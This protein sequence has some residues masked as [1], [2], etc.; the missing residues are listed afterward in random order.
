MNK[1]LRISFSLKNS[2]R[3]NSILYSLKQIPLVK[4]L[5]PNSLYQVQGLKIFANI[6]SV[7][8][9]IASTFLGKFLYFT[10]MIVGAANLYK[11]VPT[12]GSTLHILLFLSIIGAFMNTYM[13]NP[14]RDKYYAMIL[15]R[16][17]A[18]DYTLINYI[19]SILKIIIGF[20]PFVLIYGFIKNI[21]LWLCLLIPFFI[22]GLKLTMTAFFLRDYEKTGKT[23]N[24][25]VLGK[26]MW[27]ATFVIL[28]C[29]YGLP[30]LKIVMPVPVTIG[31]ML[32]VVIYGFVS[33]RK[34]LAFQNYR[35][36]YQQILSKA[37]NQ[38]DAAKEMSRQMSRKAISADTA[39]T[40]QKKGFAY[41][42]ELFIKRHQK[43]LW[44]S[45]KKIA[46]I[47]SFLIL[48]LFLAFY[49][50]PEIKGMIN[51][52][53]LTFLP[54]FVFIMYAINRGTGFTTAL[55]MNCDHS[56]LT[57]SFYKQ[58]AFVLNLFQIRLREIIKINLLPAAVIGIGLVILLYASGGTNNPLNYA[59]LL[60]SILCMSI[61][62]S[63]HYLTIYYLLQPYNAATESKSGTYQLVLS[64]TY[65][66]CF[67]IMKVKLPILFFGLACI[68]FCILYCIV[69]CVLIY[70]FAPKTF[71][72]RI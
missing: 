18:R 69:A 58:P 8:W 29:A 57:Y 3:V 42:N 26:F 62:F 52:I 53:L 6:L 45:V 7:M 27:T 1:T 63:V 30:V 39:I 68:A 46:Y 5:L 22:A 55:F 28:A 2:Y 40:S 11:D 23:T 50:V 32:L 12:V 9:E 13:F 17:D 19:Y 37:M 35:D 43:I 64:A 70:K 66:L 16:M 25:N 20:L 15:M 51:E 44:K 31:I 36:M 33:L 59:V 10:F 56:L 61:F 71:K 65:L 54:Y 72:L 49:L 60:V 21:P 4:K 47:S 34:I 24:E 67:F 14:T 38:M 41:L 48:G